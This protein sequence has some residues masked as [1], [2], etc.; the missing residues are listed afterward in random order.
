MLQLIIHTDDR[1][2]AAEIAQMAIEGGCRWIQL[3]FPS[4]TDDDIKAFA[5]DIIE[6]CRESAAFLTVQ[7]RPQ[8]ARELGLHGVHLDSADRA[9]VA[10]VREDLGP[11]AVIG[12]TLTDDATADTLKGLD[13]DYVSIPYG[14]GLSDAARIA[15]TVR[16]DMPEL[17][18][19]LFGDIQ[20]ADIE[21]C[22]NVGAAGIAVDSDIITHAAD[23][24]AKVGQLLDTLSHSK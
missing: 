16:H 3:N 14:L 21:Q 10:A 7:A 15:D 23:P 11:E 6:L 20:C 1:Y 24:V 8:L 18:I 5:S 19:V 12:V 2:S 17:P 22:V 9:S 13:I 4:L